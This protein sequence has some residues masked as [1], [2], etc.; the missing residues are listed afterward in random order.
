M[1]EMTSYAPGTFCWVEVGTTDAAAASSFYTKLFGWEAE[2]VMEGP[3]GNYVMLR[4][5]GKDVAGLYQL[6][7]EQR[8]QGIPPHWLPYVSVTDASER[9][10]KAA[11]LGGKVLRDAFDVLDVGRMALVQDPTGAIVALWQAK[12]H[13][14]ARLVNEPA[15]LCW[16]ELAT[17]DTAQ[18]RRFYTALFD[19]KP[20][21]QDLGPMKY[22]TFLNGERPNGGMLEMTEEWTGTPPHWMTYIAVEDCDRTV[23][24]AQEL[25]GV[26]CV[27]PTEIP[28]IGRFAVLQDPQGAMF[29]VIKLVNAT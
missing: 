23:A 25:G 22:T 28:N 4:Q 16:N 29:A 7:T 5:K 2:K 3:E 14:G 26:V 27:E 8:A 17:T 19:W 18:A 9:A 6:S 11:A 13:I 1:T 20:Q 24:R 15:S 10:R 21:E 12:K